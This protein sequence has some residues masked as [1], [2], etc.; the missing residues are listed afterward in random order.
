MKEEL[1]KAKE[2]VRILGIKCKKLQEAG[3]TNNQLI[4]HLQKQLNFYQ[5]RFYTRLGGMTLDKSMMDYR[6]VAIA[7]DWV[8]TYQDEE[9]NGPEN[10]RMLNISVLDQSNVMDI[11]RVNKHSIQKR[12]RNN[13]GSMHILPKE[14]EGFFKK[15]TVTS[16][17]KVLTATMRPSSTVLD[18]MMRPQRVLQSTQDLM[19]DIEFGDARETFKLDESKV[20]LR[21]LAKGLLID[22]TSRAKFAYSKMKNKKFIDF[23]SIPVPYLKLERSVSCP[24]LIGPEKTSKPRESWADATLILDKGLGFG[25]IGEDYS[26]DVDFDELKKL[27]S[28]HA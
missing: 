11:S 16:P 14:R 4:D 2:L 25:P 17:P 27:I 15:P 7:Q 3:T 6:D 10:E 24:P 9:A 21:Q 26:I 19:P 8:K 23:A 13:K 1:K 28:K 18:E 5:T 20:Y 12:K 22:R